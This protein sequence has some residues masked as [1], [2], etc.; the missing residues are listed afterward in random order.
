VPRF[1]ISLGLALIVIAGAC[2]GDTGSEDAAPSDN[3]QSS[4]ISTETDRPCDGGAFPDDV[5]FRELLCALQWA[6]VDV[7]SAG[8]EID[9]S[10]G[11]RSSQAI[12][13]HGDDRPTAIA[14]LE[15]ILAEMRAAAA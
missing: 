4:D 5:P 8:G 15:A 7:M 13:L 9:T 2:S 10:W 3:S 12:L 1:F 6:Q 14:D 11:P